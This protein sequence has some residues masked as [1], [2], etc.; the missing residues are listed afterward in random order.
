MCPA[1][2]VVEPF[3]GHRPGARNLDAA[4]DW[5]ISFIEALEAGARV[6]EDDVTV[7][8]RAHQRGSL[9]TV[10]LRRRLFRYVVLALSL[11]RLS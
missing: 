11:G 5:T 6:T 10:E 2:A 3:I 9:W 4:A 8:G 1:I 7:P